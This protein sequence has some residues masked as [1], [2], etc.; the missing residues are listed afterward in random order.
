M[1]D[2]KAEIDTLF[3]SLERLRIE[4]DRFFRKERKF[5]PLQ[6]RNRL[7]G[8]LRRMGTRSLGST[9]DQFRLANLQGRFQSLSGLWERQLRDLEE[10]RTPGRPSTG[11]PAGP[12]AGPV[13]DEHLDRAVDGWKTARTECGLPAGDAEAAA[14][15]ELLRRKAAEIAGSGGGRVEFSVSVEGGKPKIRAALRKGD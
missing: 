13:S 7:E 8:V 14:F 12:G 4:F 6:D 9:G 11:A 15:R 10:G 3:Q 2:P 1:S 5:P